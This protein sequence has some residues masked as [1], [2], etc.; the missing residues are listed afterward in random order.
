MKLCEWL[1]LELGLLLDPFPP[2]DILPL[3]LLE[4]LVAILLEVLLLDEGLTLG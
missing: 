4:L 1:G 2:L 3:V